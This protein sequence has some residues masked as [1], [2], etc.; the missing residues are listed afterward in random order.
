MSWKFQDWNSRGLEELKNKHKVKVVKT[1][2]TVL[3]AQLKAWDALIAE[4]SKDNP[5]FTKVMESQKAWARRG[6]VAARDHGR[7]ESGLRALLQEGVARLPLV[8]VVWRCLS[9]RSIG[10]AWCVS[11]GELSPWRRQ[12]N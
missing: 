1:P 3:D 12:S 5:F 4:K 10:A 9:A 8:C 6:R 2:Q 7:S 11:R